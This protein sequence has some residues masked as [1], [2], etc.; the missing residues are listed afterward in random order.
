V[1]PL[2]VRLRPD[3]RDALCRFAADQYRDPQDQAA[4]FV[5]EGLRRAG[6]LPAQPVGRSRATAPARD[7]AEAHRD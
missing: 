7:Q 5:L 2:Y 6:A 4:W 1:Q 3:T